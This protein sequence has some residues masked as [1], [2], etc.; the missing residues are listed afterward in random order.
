ML[1][2]HC[3][4]FIS[5]ANPEKCI[6]YKQRFIGLFLRVFGSFTCYE[7]FWIY[8]CFIFFFFG[9]LR[10]YDLAISLPFLRSFVFR[11]HGDR[12]F[13]I[14]Y[15]LLG[16]FLAPVGQNYLYSSKDKISRI[17]YRIH[18]LWIVWFLGR[19]DVFVFSFFFLS[20]RRR[21]RHSILV[22]IPVNN[23][24]LIHKLQTYLRYAPWSHGIWYET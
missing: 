1:V 3:M 12:F 7:S 21:H 17:V 19:H 20:C 4:M 24:A 8:F 22:K 14:Y 16:A 11:L 13:W 23:V 15:F 9:S 6:V 2:H 10:E 5:W 18:V